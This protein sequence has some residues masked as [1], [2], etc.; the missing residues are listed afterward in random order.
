MKKKSLCLSVLNSIILF[1]VA[2]FAQEKINPAQ[3]WPRFRGHNGRGISHAATVPH[4]WEHSD[5]N[6]KIDLAGT[7]HSSPV[8]WDDKLYVTSADEKRHAGLLYAVNAKTGAVRWQADFHLPTYKKHGDNS[9][10]SST[11]V[12][13]GDNV[14][15]LWMTDSLST[16]AAFSHAGN[17]VWETFMDGAHS[18]HGTGTSPVLYGDNIFFTLEQ[19]DP[20]PFT[21]KWIALDR[22]TG[23]PV[24]ELE[25]KTVSRNSFSTP[26]AVNLTD[27]QDGLLFTS[28][29]HGLSCIRAHDGGVVWEVDVF[30][31]RCL[32][33]PVLAGEFFIGTC[34]NKL[35]AVKGRQKPVVAYEHKTKLAPYVP[36]PVYKDGLLFLF[37]DKGD[38]VCLQA[39]TGRELWTERPADKFYASPVWINGYLYGFTRKGKVVVVRASRQYELIAVN[40]IPE[41]THATPAIAG[42]ALYFRTFSSLYSVGGSQK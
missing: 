6:W 23:E 7:G 25:R 26:C 28:Q 22:R 33:S 2:L 32:T 3:C 37:M 24:W 36:T 8:V 5:Y 31:H 13:D 30:D 34:K 14:Y 41:G 27:E 4:R 12:V 21:G 40:S 20:S 9:Y 10:A 38:I 42:G 17:K 11:P 29:A 39:E 35:V 16:L 15:V 18:K 19:E 1:S